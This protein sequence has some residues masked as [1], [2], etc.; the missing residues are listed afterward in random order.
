MKK[1][2]LALLCAFLA[3]C[4][5][6]CASAFTATLYEE[7]GK[8]VIKNGE[9]DSFTFTVNDNTPIPAKSDTESRYF[10][11]YVTA[12]GKQNHKYNIYTEYE[13]D[14]TLTARYLDRYDMIPGENVVKNGD[15]D[16]DYINVTPSNGT[17]T[18]V[19]EKDGNR[20]L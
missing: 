19:T 15:F 1:F 9:S 10:L 4:L 16:E 2:R 6:V 3:V 17:L 20:V 13:G 8:T 12:D 11:G 7:D 14:L 5:A 18:I